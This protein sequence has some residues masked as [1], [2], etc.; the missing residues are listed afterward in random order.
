MRVKEFLLEIF[1]SCLPYGRKVIVMYVLMWIQLQQ[2]SNVGEQKCFGDN[3]SAL[4]M[5]CSHDTSNVHCQ[6]SMT[7]HS[8]Q[9]DAVGLFLKTLLP[10]FPKVLTVT[11]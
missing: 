9:H 4:K 6:G 5:C 8:F 7:S 10:H 3:F 11:K 1:R 2:P